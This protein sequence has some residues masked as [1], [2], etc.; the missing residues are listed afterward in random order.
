[1]LPGVLEELVTPFLADFEKEKNIEVEFVLLP[2]TELRSKV[3]IDL[4]AGAGR[5]DVVLVSE[6]W[7][8][9]FGDYLEPLTPFLENP[10]LADPDYDFDDLIPGSLIGGRY[11]GV[12]VGLPWRDSA[13]ILFWNK[14][15][16][17][18][19]GLT[20]PPET[21]D[22]ALE[23]AQKL[24]KDTNDDGT[25]DIW[26]FAIQ[27][28]SGWQAAIEFHSVL[29][30]WG[31]T[32]L[33]KD[34]KKATFN[35]P[36]GVEALQ[37]YVDLVQKHKVS[38]P[39]SVTWGWDPIITALQQG[40]VAMTCAYAPYAGLMDDPE[41]SKV[42]GQME[43]ALC[44]KKERSSTIGAAWQLSIAE[45]A[46]NKEAA[47][48]LIQYLTSKK[49]Q[50]ESTK[51]GNLPVRF[52]VYDDPELAAQRRDFEATKEALA[53]SSRLPTIP[54]TTEIMD[55]FGRAVNEALTGIKTPQQALEEAAA[56]VNA[57]L[58]E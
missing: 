2:F 10:E 51:I 4:V 7:M 39:A 38:P 3:L 30:S 37:F 6:A 26:G 34:W 58:S 44:P 50:L 22:E 25:P 20:H 35:S 17:E 53:T 19:A 31:E 15:L 52:S 48:Q 46:E 32:M 28:E 21:L 55:I 16:F 1:M 5:Y 47:F 24:T 33:D 40:T 54:Q 45:D 12:R 9:E 49:I 43:Y 13:R 27:G 41:A 18:E 42:V 29:L 14:K 11:K 57:L 23:M 8:G 56:E 36:K